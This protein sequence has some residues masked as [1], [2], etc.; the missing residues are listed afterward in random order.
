MRYAELVRLRLEKV[1]FAR[2]IFHG[3]SGKID[4]L[5]LI[6]NILKFNL[7][8]LSSVYFFFSVDSCITTAFL[9]SIIFFDN[10][11]AESYLLEKYA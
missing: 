3:S 5:H 2:G 1:F 9:L 10:T 7:Y 8:C 4:L 11:V 6:Y